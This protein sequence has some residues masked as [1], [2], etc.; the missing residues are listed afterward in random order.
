MNAA[1]PL[2]SMMNGLS[3]GGQQDPLARLKDVA[4]PIDPGFWP[5]PWWF[6]GL[7]VLALLALVGFI[8]FLKHQQ[9]P[10]WYRKAKAN[11]KDEISELRKNP[12]AQQLAQLN[13][14]LKRIAYKIDGR[15]NVAHLQ[16]EKWCQ[17][18]NQK[19][20]CKDFTTG[21]G[22]IL[23]D[24][25]NPYLEIEDR[26]V[27]DLGKAVLKW[28]DKHKYSKTHK[29]LALN[30]NLVLA[31]P[32]PEK[33]PTEKAQKLTD[34]EAQKS[35]PEKNELAEILSKVKKDIES[36]EHRIKGRHD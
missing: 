27:K 10:K 3:G 20:Q 31:K 32:T 21:A 8:I 19:G 34:A 6:Y 23:A 13:Q 28:L 11:L 18:L 1:S 16:G 17:W 26:Q 30:E 14:I 36:I 12:T 5:P 15:N 33:K 22:H 35:E 2:A 9:G 24:I 7:I 4:P 29:G 25:Y